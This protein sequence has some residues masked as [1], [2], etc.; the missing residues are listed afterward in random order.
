MWIGKC[1]GYYVDF[2]LMKTSSNE[3]FNLPVF[4]EHLYGLSGVSHIIISKNNIILKVFIINNSN[5]WFNNIVLI[6][7]AFGIV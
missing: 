5:Q 4:T 3:E 7:L 2:K 1:D 6:Q